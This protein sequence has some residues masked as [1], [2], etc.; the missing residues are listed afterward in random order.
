M[1]ILE[2]FDL[3]RSYRATAELAGCDHHTVAHYVQLRELGALSPGHA[4]S[5]QQLI[6]PY[7]PKVEEWVD[8][9][10]GKV[11]ADVAHERLL[12]LGYLGSERTTRR[13]VAAAKKRYRAGHRRVYRPW[14]PEPGMWFQW[15]FTDGPRVNGRPTLL[16]CAWLAWSKSR[17][18]LPIWDKSLSSV[19][20]CIDTSL[21]RWGGCPT[22][23]LTDNEKTVTVNHIAG[24]AVR[25]PSMLA[26]AR[27]YGLTIVTCVPSDPESKGG[28]EATA[29]IAQADLVPT[30]AN[31]LPD[32]PS[33]RALE[34]ACEALEREVNHRL[35]RVT[36]RIPAEMLVEERLRLHSLPA[37]PYTLAFGEPRTVGRTTPMVDVDHSQ[38]SAPY[39]LAGEVVWVRE[40]GNDIV[41]IHAG[42]EGAREVARHERTVPGA[43]RIDPTHLPPQPAGPLARRPKPT[44]EA[45]TD[46]VAIGPGAERWLLEAAAQGATRIR[47]QMAE[48]VTLAALHGR[49]AVDL[50]LEQAAAAQRFG[51][52]D[53]SAIVTH[54]A[55]AR[56]G[57]SHRAGEHHSLQPGTSAWHRFG[58]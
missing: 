22:Y 7:L 16:Y 54:Q 31:L 29:R 27:H 35:H 4:K 43:P 34:R 18:I 19:V 17:V 42:P 53:V 47:A 21:R 15:D 57:P 26:A 25:N 3:T 10:R 36:R 33:F 44:T 20:H 23:G 30:E 24:I 40:H 11:R 14:I 28:V 39:Q 37:Q 51:Q 2:A 46:F 55:A 50:A 58:R 48:A 8:Q 13:A 5:R 52:G 32:Y 6:E 9:S 49:T 56:P 38:Y 41:I 45:E 12:A 1:E